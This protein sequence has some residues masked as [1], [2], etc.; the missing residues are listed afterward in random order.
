M[1]YYDLP[2]LD[3]W[4][5]RQPEDPDAEAYEHF[6]DAA[7]SMGFEELLAELGEERENALEKYETEECAAE[8]MRE[9]WVEQ[10]IAALHEPPDDYDREDDW[11]YED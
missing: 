3:A 6:T 11:D 4:I 7:S 2:G 10:Q 9:E 8:A 5:T 1:G